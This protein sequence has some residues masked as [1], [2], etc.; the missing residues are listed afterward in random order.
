M[1]VLKINDTKYIYLTADGKD[2]RP[3]ISS[4]SFEQYKLQIKKEQKETLEKLNNE[5]TRKNYASHDLKFNINNMHNIGMLLIIFAFLL[6]S[7]EVIYE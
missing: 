4:I 1:S 2:T 3:V 7:Y 5:T 6:L